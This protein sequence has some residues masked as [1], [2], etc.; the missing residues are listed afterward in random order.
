MLAKTWA[1]AMILMSMPT[2]AL[3]DSQ[4]DCQAAGGSYLRGVVVSR[5]QF[6]RGTEFPHGVELSH[7]HL[8]LRPDGDRGTYDI[9]MDNVFAS[10]YDRAGEAV[11]APLAQITPGDHLELCGK[12]YSSGYGMDWVHTNCGDTP[13][14]QTP[15]GWTKI[16]APDGTL[17]ANL[18]G[19][20][21]YCGLWKRR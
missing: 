10:G 9:A 15:D 19:S 13:T 20:T 4:S 21:E 7:T 2:L 14:S 3:A 6:R 16:I 18:E 12:P 5:P 11:P 1:S 17:S 8:R